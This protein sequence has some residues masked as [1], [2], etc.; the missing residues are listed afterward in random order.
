MAKLLI[1]KSFLIWHV[2][3][4]TKYFIGVILFNIIMENN[5]IRIRIVYLYRKNITYYEKLKNWLWLYTSNVHVRFWTFK[6]FH[7]SMEIAVYWGCDRGR[8]LNFLWFMK[9][10]FYNIIVF[11]WNL[12]LILLH[13]RSIIIFRNLLFFFRARTEMSYF[14]PLMILSRSNHLI[15]LNHV[16]FPDDYFANVS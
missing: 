10:V 13:D 12:I 3:I 4:V 14:L 8:R 9:Y 5:S 6:N 7:V 11:M 16:K 15:L 1:L 2:K